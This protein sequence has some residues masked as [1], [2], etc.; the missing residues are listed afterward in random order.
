[1][2]SAL[3]DILLSISGAKVIIFF[4]N[5]LI[6]FLFLHCFFITSIFSSK[7]RH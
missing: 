2:L 1:M 6:K 3:L 5:F 4:N 7:R